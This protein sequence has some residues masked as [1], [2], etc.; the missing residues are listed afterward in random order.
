MRITQE[1]P[2]ST[3]ETEKNKESQSTISDIE[4]YVNK[5]YDEL[6]IS[7]LKRELLQEVHLLIQ[8]ETNNI[9]SILQIKMIIFQRRL[10]N[11]LRKELKEENIVIE[12]LWIT[13]DKIS[14]VISVTI[15]I[16][17]IMM[18]SP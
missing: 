8:R 3:K 1:T 2:V 5:K 17:L 9:I 6:A 12:N 13:V 7:S 18:I 4:D 10:V 16:P 11:F 15:R 14:T